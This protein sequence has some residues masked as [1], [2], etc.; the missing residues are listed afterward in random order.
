MTPLRL[1]AGAFRSRADVVAGFNWAATRKPRRGS[2]SIFCANAGI[3]ESSPFVKSDAALFR[4][5]MDVN[6]MGVV[7]S[8]QAA[9]LR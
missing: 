2:R 5:M 4:R 6:F 7:H 1:A 9:C 8:I 3:A